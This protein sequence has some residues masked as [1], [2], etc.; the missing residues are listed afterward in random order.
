MAHVLS[1]LYDF[2]NA[3]LQ[4]QDK[5]FVPVFSAWMP[6]QSGGNVVGSLSLLSEA[7]N[8]HTHTHTHT[9]TILLLLQITTVITIFKILGLRVLNHVYVFETLR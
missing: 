5:M 1:T 6:H 7:E 8:T 4:R 3:R 2:I 9:H